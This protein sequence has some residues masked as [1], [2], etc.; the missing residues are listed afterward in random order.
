MMTQLF[1]V[2]CNYGVDCHCACLRL[3][4]LCIPVRSS[5]IIPVVTDCSHCRMRVCCLLLA[6]DHACVLL[7]SY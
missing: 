6:A 5:S 2:P 3:L 1:V 7:A 4:T